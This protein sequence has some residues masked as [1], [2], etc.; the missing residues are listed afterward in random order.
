M[1][2]NRYIPD[3]E[4]PEVLKQRLVFGDRHQINALNSLEEKINRI[5]TKK[6]KLSN[7]ELKYF[8]VTIYYKRSINIKVLAVDEEDAEE[9]AEA[10]ANFAC[11]DM[12]INHISTKEIKNRLK[13]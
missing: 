8:N 3:R 5:I 9:K 7:G 2:L 4:L 1:Q 10:E 12:D 13:K 6:A 11:V